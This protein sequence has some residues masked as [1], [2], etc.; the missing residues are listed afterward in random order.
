MSNNEIFLAVEGTSRLSASL[1]TGGYRL[2]SV[3]IACWRNSRRR[4]TV[5]PGSVWLNELIWREFYRHLMTYY[6]SLCKHRP[7]VA[8]TDRVQ[9]QSNSTYLKAWQ[10]GKTGYLIVDAAMRQL[11]STGWMHNRLRMITASFW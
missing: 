5:G 8:W 3:C 9:W 4:W 7:F 6:P 11:N 2:A 1:A 10:E